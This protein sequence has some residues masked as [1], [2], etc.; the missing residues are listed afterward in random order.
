MDNTKQAAQLFAQAL[1]LYDAKVKSAQANAV[2]EIRILDLDLSE[3]KYTRENPLQVAFPFKS[4]R[5][6]QATD[7]NTFVNLIPE[8]ADQGRGSVRLGLLDAF[9]TEFGMSKAYIF[10]TPQA[11]KKVRLIFFTTSNISNGRQV[12]DQNSAYTVIKMGD[13]EAI[14]DG[15]TV[16]HYGQMGTDATM[17]KTRLPSGQKAL[18]VSTFSNGEI[19]L[20]DVGRYQANVLKVPAGYEAEILQCKVVTGAGISW[21]GSR[22]LYMTEIFA[23]TYPSEFDIISINDPT[24]AIHFASFNVTNVAGTFFFQPEIVTNPLYN[25]DGRTRCV[26]K[27]GST[28][29]CFNWHI[30]GSWTAGLMEFYWLVRFYK[31]V[32]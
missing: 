6:E 19:T 3:T 21:A 25:L 26:V 18:N 20:T 5:V 29:K 4:L 23:Q 1:S 27:G 17:A 14:N 13:A 32:G 7:L 31:S 2:D 8:N 28:G 24:K 22:Q 9:N 11:G 15:F 10:W 16:L 12:L 30:N